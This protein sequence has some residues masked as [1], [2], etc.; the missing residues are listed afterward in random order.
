MP[1]AGTY[2][3]EGSTD[4]LLVSPEKAR[5]LAWKL[6]SCAAS[7]SSAY[8]LDQDDRIRLETTLHNSYFYLDIER[9]LDDLASCLPSLGS[10]LGDLGVDLARSVDML[11]YEDYRAAAIIDDVNPD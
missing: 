9:F 5:M 7:L 11:V 6:Q 8:A 1:F 10:E 4:P 2:E 3:P